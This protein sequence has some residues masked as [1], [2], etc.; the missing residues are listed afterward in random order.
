MPDLNLNEL[1]RNYS[2]I[3]A[4]IAM[5][6]IQFLM[7]IDSFPYV[8]GDITRKNNPIGIYALTPENFILGANNAV[9]R[10]DKGYSELYLRVGT[11]Q[12]LVKEVGNS[13]T[14]EVAQLFHAVGRSMSPLQGVFDINN[15]RQALMSELNKY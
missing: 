14:Q 6:A 8:W 12:A 7:Q 3:T 2:N 11:R 1:P 13:R 15:I 10:I 4:P 9:T 5:K